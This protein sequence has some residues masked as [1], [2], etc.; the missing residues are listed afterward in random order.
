MRIKMILVQLY[1][2]LSFK[3]NIFFNNQKAFIKL[4]TKIDIKLKEY[5]S[6]KKL[7]QILSY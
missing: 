3:I 5:F 1:T 4:E 7:V 6:N 2:I